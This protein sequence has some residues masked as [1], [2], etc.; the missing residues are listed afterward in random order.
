VESRRLFGLIPNY[1]TSPSLRNYEPLTTGEKIKI[2]SED[3]F[4]RYSELVGNSAAVTISNAYYVNNRMAG[5]AA[6]KLRIQ[7]GR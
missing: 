2:A 5:D 6:S 7:L 3:A 4:D 1:R